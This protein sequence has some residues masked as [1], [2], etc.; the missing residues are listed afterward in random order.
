MIL[1]GFSGG[2]RSGPG[3]PTE[4]RRSSS[5]RHEGPAA[6]TGRN[7]RDRFDGDP[8]VSR[9]YETLDDDTA[10][11][12]VLAALTERIGG[13]NAIALALPKQQGPIPLDW[14]HRVDPALL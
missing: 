14:M 4:S 12:D 8:I 10:W 1:P 9:I 11:T 2:R 3:C 5:R 6:M 13:E 7:P